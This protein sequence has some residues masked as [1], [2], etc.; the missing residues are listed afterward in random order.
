M[1]F[2][3][4]LLGSSFVVG[5][6]FMG[7]AANLGN[8]IHTAHLGTVVHKSHLA[9]W[10]MNESIEVIGLLDSLLL[11]MLLLFDGCL[12]LILISLGTS[13]LIIFL[14]SK[15]VDSTNNFSAVD[16]DSLAVDMYGAII[17]V[18]SSLTLFVLLLCN[19][20]L[21]FKLLS[22]LFS[23]SLNHFSL[24]FT[25]GSGLLLSLRWLLMSQS[26]RSLV[27]LVVSLV[28]SE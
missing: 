14:G 6:G 24:Q 26:L 15:V 13:F 16:M 4:V 20:F 25:L 2:A 12:G 17:L 27:L 8:G 7:G 5:V 19:S 21:G 1:L 18:C 3:V 11:I 22:L 23:S 28:L 9:I 10:F